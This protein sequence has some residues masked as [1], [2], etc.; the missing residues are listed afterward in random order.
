MSVVEAD[1]TNLLP[2]F[3]KDFSSSFAA[4]PY[5]A[6][7]FID[8]LLLL[9]LIGNLSFEKG[10]GVKITMGYAVGALFTLV[11]PALFYGVFSSVAARNHYAFAKIAQYF[12]VLAIV[13]RID[14][15][16]VYLVCI[17]LFF[18]VATPLQNATACLQKTSGA[19]GKTLL[20]I[21]INLAAFL[22]TLF[23]NRF[24]Y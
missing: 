1:I 8:V 14:L 15:L 5:S 4:V 20:S 24:Y 17:V 13:G 6:P 18:Y 16:F 12:P 23:C 19:H 11:F 7:H 10:D 2:F 9:P 3:E 21:L 22:F